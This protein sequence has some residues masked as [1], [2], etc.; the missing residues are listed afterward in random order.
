MLKYAI[1]ILKIVVIFLLL[2]LAVTLFLNRA[3]I[4]MPIPLIPEVFAQNEEYHYV[5]NNSS[6]VDGNPNKGFYSNFTAEKY[7][8]DSIYDTLS[9][10]DTAPVVNDTENFVDNN[11]SNV[12]GHA[13]HGASSNF[14]AQQYAD[15]IYDTLTEEDTGSKNVL[16][17]LWVNG[18]TST[19]TAWTLTGS[20]PYLNAVD[21]P[22]NIVS[23]A[24]RNIAVSRF[25]FSDLTDPTSA[26]VSVQVCVY[27]NTAGDDGAIIQLYN[28]SGGPY[29]IAT[30]YFTSS[31]TWYNFTCTST[32]PTFQEVNG[33]QLRLYSQ[34]QGSTMSTVRVDAAL[35]RVTY[36]T[37]NYELDIEFQWTTADND[38]QN[39]YLCI[40]T[41]TL[42]SENLQVDVW[43]GSGWTNIISALSASAWNNVSIT[44]YL[45][46][47]TITFR[48]HGASETNDLTQSTWQIECSL[49]HVWSIAVN[50]N[51]DLEI[52]WTSVVFTRT[53]EQL[54]IYVRSTGT[55][56]IRVYV[57][58]GSW[59][60][61]F[62]DLAANSWNNV[63]VT[64]WLTSS[65]FT[66]RFLGGSETNDAIQ[67]TWQIDSSLLHTWDVGY[68]L[69]LRIMDYS[70][71]DA[72]SDAQV[73]INNG[74]DHVQASN[75]NGWANY[76]G[77]G[78]AVTVK[79]QYFGFWVNGT[80]S[81]IMDSDKTI[82]VQCKLYDV[83]VLV[84]E[85]VQNAYLVSANVT[86][87]NSTSV[88]GNE[89]T[90]G[91]TGNNGQVQLLNLP[92]NTLTF[93]QYGGASYS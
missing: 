23:T 76:T 51:L 43:N 11:S 27:A 22:T 38:E 30:Q 90:S 55:E 44:T 86:V 60:L 41:G 82:D 67:D 17:Q 42:S 56:D 3:M 69:N 37:T 31:Y 88:E 40:K 78:G 8:P 58:N 21:N 9:E 74:T 83:T 32:L 66:V 34:R 87:F 68:S 81:V 29:N 92:N 1:N 61:V 65:T 49:I 91:T 71:T 52:Q 48:F 79:V 36:N 5:D 59:N 75:G 64:D 13:N 35:L 14:T 45:T 12:D 54:C 19:E 72:I 63:S 16:T 46:A 39:E 89:I 26:I 73:T 93:T 33:A 15:N 28:S 18:F 70:M 7:G 85:G 4:P 57:W 6:D 80:F 50:Y 2:C 62:N 47:A 25:N 24:T 53:Y 77:V 10:A 84:Q 20:T